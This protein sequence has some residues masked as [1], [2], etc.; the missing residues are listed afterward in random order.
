MAPLPKKKRSKASQG[1]HRA[2][3]GMRLT[4]LGLCPQ[5]RSPKLSHQACRVCGTYNGR[6]VIAV[7]TPEAAE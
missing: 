1:S 2:H 6:Q 5:C 3:Q 7:A 4:S